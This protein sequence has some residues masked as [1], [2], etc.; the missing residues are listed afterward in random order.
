MPPCHD[1]STEG[2]IV[3]FQVSLQVLR[4]PILQGSVER[5]R[6]RSKSMDA[7]LLDQMLRSSAD[8]VGMGWCWWNEANEGPGMERF[9]GTWGRVVFFS[10]E[11]KKNA[12]TSQF[13]WGQGSSSLIQT[14][15]TTSFPVDPAEARLRQLP[16]VEKGACDHWE[17]RWKQVQLCADL[18]PAH[19]WQ[20]PSAIRIPQIDG[21]AELIH[22]CFPYCFPL[23]P[24]FLEQVFPPRGCLG[25]WL[26]L[27]LSQA[28]LVAM[29]CAS[30]GFS[31]VELV[32]AAR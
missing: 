14:H 9:D 24:Y 7:Q 25:H 5:L 4:L 16:I 19:L 2:F 21:G 11:S 17:S 30:W 1:R 15:M 10:I 12:D 32:A 26:P 8:H 13:V 29:A 31:L 20:K 3:G 27:S 6:K 18:N 28:A 22:R 23:P